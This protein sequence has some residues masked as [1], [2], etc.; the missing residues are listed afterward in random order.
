M[1]EKKS[2]VRAKFARSA[3]IVACICSLFIMCTFSASALVTSAPPID[4]VYGGTTTYAFV[5]IKSLKYVSMTSSKGFYWKDIPTSNNMNVRGIGSN[6]VD[7]GYPLAGST[8][9]SVY[10]DEVKVGV[11][12]PRGTY[13]GV[14]TD[15]NNLP[16]YYDDY[17]QG[18]VCDIQLYEILPNQSGK[19]NPN[20]ENL[21]YQCA[22]IVFN[23]Y[24]FTGDVIA[25]P[26][27]YQGNHY[28]MFKVLTPTINLYMGMSAPLKVGVVHLSATVE[29]YDIE[30]K[31][32]HSIFVES[33]LDFTFPDD[34]TGSYH[35]YQLNP[36]LWLYNTAC[37]MDN[38]RFEDSLTNAEFIAI[39]NCNV[40]LGNVEN[41]LNDLYSGIYQGGY[42]G[43]H[44]SVPSLRPYNPEFAQYPYAKDNKS[45][46]INYALKDQLIEI[47]HTTHEVIVERPVEVSSLS[48]FVGGIVSSTLGITIVEGVT[49]GGVLFCFVVVALT[50][51]VL[52][53][54]AGG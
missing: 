44:I 42:G 3:V 49:L 28:S 11:E 51:A 8:Y 9:Q 19:L 47:S 5:P 31:E 17:K 52:K 25:N 7:V 50:I 36:M 35:T 4:N 40:R 20:G 24:Y 27:Q 14:L 43:I 32:N 16:S 45:N 39:R 1:K 46:D 12:E 38:G 2:P 10:S 34:V 33:Q 29:Y 30:T 23:D 41:V 21:S 54:F 18:G 48:A 13:Y 22:D 53:Y 26:P 37:S 6:W 15:L